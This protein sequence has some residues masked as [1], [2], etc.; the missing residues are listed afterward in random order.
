MIIRKKY[1]TFRAGQSVPKWMWNFEHYGRD[2]D[3]RNKGGKV[4]FMRSC[5]AVRVMGVKSNT[6]LMQ[7]TGGECMIKVSNFF[8]TKMGGVNGATGV[9]IFDDDQLHMA[10]M[11]FSEHINSLINN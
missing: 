2:A 6:L 10:S 4:V 1:Y 9:M 7:A 8:D 5:V 11:M 3:F